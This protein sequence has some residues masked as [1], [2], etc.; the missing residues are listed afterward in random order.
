MK[1]PWGAEAQFPI[2]VLPSLNGCVSEP[3]MPEIAAELI[4]KDQ[5]SG[6]P[7]KSVSVK[8]VSKSASPIS[9]GF[10]SQKIL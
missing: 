2:F 5:G 3:S 9:N 7:A 10:L 4:A 1:A 6:Q 8:T